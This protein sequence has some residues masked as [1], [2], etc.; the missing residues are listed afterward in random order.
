MKARYRRENE[1]NTNMKL[2]TQ[3]E[4]NYVSSIV[5]QSRY[6]IRDLNAFVLEFYDKHNLDKYYGFKMDMRRYLLDNQESRNHSV[7]H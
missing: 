3:D 6:M 2:I 5:K 1:M 4:W 7:T